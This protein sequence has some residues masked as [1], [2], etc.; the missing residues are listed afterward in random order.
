M[1]FFSLIIS[2]VQAAPGVTTHVLDTSIG[3]P[4]QVNILD[5]LLLNFFFV[6]VTPENDFFLE[7][8]TISTNFRFA[9]TFCC[10]SIST[11]Y[12]TR[13]GLSR[14]SFEYSSASSAVER[15]RKSKIFVRNGI[16][17]LLYFSN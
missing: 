5:F 2:M 3:L 15:P 16:L 6:I 14:T 9:K 1:K 12:S 4:G 10:L 13:N 11:G 7:K 17:Q 8:L